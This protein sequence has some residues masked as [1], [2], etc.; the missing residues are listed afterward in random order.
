MTKSSDT[1]YQSLGRS[2]KRAPYPKRQERHGK[3]SW[4]E[5][6]VWIQMKGRC[7]NGSNKRFKYYGGRGIKISTRW[8]LSFDAFIEDMGRRPAVGMTLER[9][10]NDGNYESGNVV[11]KSGKLQQRN[12]RNNRWIEFNGRKQLSV[13]WEKE[14][15]M[16]RGT[17]RRRIVHHG[18][19]PERAIT[20]PV[21]KKFSGNHSRK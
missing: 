1:L 15:G 20:T 21:I 10:D 7:L 19:S 18:W 3:R 9:V 12:R 8:A 11:W 5:Y 16:P 6:Q 13:D 4:P 14:M 17:I 2:N